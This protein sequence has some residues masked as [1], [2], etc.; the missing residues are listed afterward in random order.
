MANEDDALAIY[1]GPRRTY[2]IF[3]LVAVRPMSLLEIL[4][5]VPGDESFMRS[6]VDGMIADD[7]ITSNDIGQFGLS[8][9][10]REIRATLDQLPQEAKTQAYKEAWGI[11]PED[12]Y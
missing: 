4:D 3:R 9:H 11:A 12:G 5:A 6:I 10:G 2:E 8:L 7:L 1:S